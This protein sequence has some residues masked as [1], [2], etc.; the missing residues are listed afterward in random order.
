MSATRVL[1]SI[2][3][4]AQSIGAIKEMVVLSWLCENMGHRFT[5]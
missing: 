2:V 1:V 3:D 5:V 4:V